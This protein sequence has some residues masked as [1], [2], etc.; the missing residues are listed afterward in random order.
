MNKEVVKKAVAP[1]KLINKLPLAVF[2][3]GSFP[4]NAHPVI[5]QIGHQNNISQF[6]HLQIPKMMA[7]RLLVPFVDRLGNG[8]TPFNYP[9]K[10]WISGVGDSLKGLV[11][12]L[13]GNLKGTEATFNPGF[14]PAYT[15]MDSD[16]YSAQVSQFIDMAF[17]PDEMPLFTNH[18]FHMMLNQP[19]MLDSIGLDKCFRNTIYF[20]QS[21][22]QPSFRNGNVTFHKD[23]HLTGFPGFYPSISGFSATGQ[24][25]GYNA[26]ICSK[27]AHDVDSLASA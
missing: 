20:N 14:G 22:A 26:Q 9:L 16:T 1:Y 7:G 25:I 10:N 5:V 23:L 12:T 21:N 4:K 2:P 18:T 3:K 24:E 17:T 13:A 19:Q 15:A 11:P 27:A 6:G 8:L